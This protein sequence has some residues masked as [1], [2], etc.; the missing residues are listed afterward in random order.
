MAAGGNSG[1]HTARPVASVSI[2]MS[3]YA[4]ESAANLEASLSSLRA[5]TLPPHQIV[6]VVDGPIDRAQEAVIARFRAFFE[7]GPTVFTPV[8]LPHNEGL[9][10]AMNVGL[11]HCGGDYTM[12]MDSDDLCMHD[13]VAVQMAYLQAHPDTDC[14]S[15]WAE[16]FFDDGTPSSLK[17]SPVSH[18]AV[19]QALRWRNVLVHPTICVRTELLRKLGG[20]RTR[21]GLLEDYDLFVRLAQAGARFHVIPKVL[22]RFRAGMD[23]RRR[24]GGLRYALHELDFRRELYRSGFLNMREFALSASLYLVFRLVTGG[25]RGRLY[26]FARH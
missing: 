23:Q 7:N 13:R 25:M 17:I 1:D 3:T 11:A 18:D 24:R 9:A 21:F 8:R 16:E 26:A 22:L 20:Y 19:L 12:R 15:A 14:V 10:A 4:R 2:L 5:Q 6:F